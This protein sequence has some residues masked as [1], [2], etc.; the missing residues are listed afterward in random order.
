[1]KKNKVS[2]LFT[3]LFISF[4]LTVK[5]IEPIQTEFSS[6]LRA[7]AYPLVTVDPYFSAWSFTDN[8][9]D[10]VVRHWTEKQF[11]FIGAIRVDGETYRFLGTENLPLKPIVPT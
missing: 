7:P 1:M 11:G 2:I 9:Y 8:L 3:F 6:S 4:S 10:D 5:S